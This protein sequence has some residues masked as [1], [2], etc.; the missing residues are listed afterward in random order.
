MR[1]ELTKLLVCELDLLKI[2]FIISRSNV[3]LFVDILL[4]LH[5]GAV[6]GGTVRKS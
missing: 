2:T 5:L 4:D 1:Q 3:E 6:I